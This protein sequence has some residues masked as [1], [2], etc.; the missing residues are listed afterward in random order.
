M[1]NISFL[2]KYNKYL[3]PFNPDYA[4][5]SAMKGKKPIKTGFCA[6]FL[7]Q[8]IVNYAELKKSN[9]YTCLQELWLLVESQPQNPGSTPFIAPLL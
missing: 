8:I 1:I 7:N 4:F 9:T 2:V 5:G 6:G 3:W